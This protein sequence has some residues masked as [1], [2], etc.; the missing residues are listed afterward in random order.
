MRP[1]RFQAT[2]T[3]IRASP[4]IIVIPLL[5]FSVM[6][7]VG[8]WATVAGADGDAAAARVAAYSRLDAVSANLELTFAQSAV[9]VRSLANLV[10]QV[11]DYDT[12]IKMWSTWVSTFFSWIPGKELTSRGNS[13]AITPAGRVA[14]MYPML[15]S[16]AVGLD[17]LQPRLRDQAIPVIVGGRIKVTGK[18]KNIGI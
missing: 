10:Q 15:N 16:T 13:L 14:A 6:L 7:A 11:P 12:V 18:S 2:A 17:I 3:A 1:R 5:L 9:P 4:Y 8:I